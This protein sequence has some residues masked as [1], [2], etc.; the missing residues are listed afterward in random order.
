MNTSN[1]G[2]DFL[3]TTI[4][5]AAAA[6]VLSLAA[7]GGSGSLSKGPAGAGGNA[8]TITTGD[9]S[10][11]NGSSSGSGSGTGSGSGSGGGTTTGSN[12]G[13]TGSGGGSGGGSGSGG[14]TVSG[15]GSTV[16][17]VTTPVVGADT[18]NAAGSVVSN[19]GAAV[20]TLGDGVSAGLGTIGTSTDP[21]GTTLAS[22]GGVVQKTSDAVSSAG[23]LVSSLGTGVLSPLAP[24]TTP[25][26]SIVGIVGNA[27]TQ[28]GGVLDQTLTSA[29]VTQLTQT[30]SQAITPITAMV[31]TTT[32]T[33]GAATGLGQPVNNLLTALG[34]GLAQAGQNI[35]GSGG[36]LLVSGVGNL[37][38]ATGQTVASAGGLVNGT[39][40]SNPLA[41]ITGLLSGVAGS[42]TGTGTGAGGVLAP[43]AGLLGSA[44]GGTGAGGVLAPVAGLLGGAGGGTG[45]GNVLAPVTSLVG[46][47]GGA[48]SGATGS[49]GGTGTGTGGVLAPVTSLVG[50]LTG[51][52]TT[53]GSGGTGGSVSE[54]FTQLIGQDITIGKLIEVADSIT[55]MYKARGYALSF[56]FIPAQTFADGVVRVT[57]VEGYV[58]DVVIK[59]NPG[60]AE[61]RIRA[62]VQ[63]MR[64]DR[65]LRQA[66]FERVINVLGMIPG[67]E[68]QA[69]VAPPHNTDGAAT[70]TLD[71]ERKPVNVSTGIDFNHPGVQGL[72]SATENGMLG[73]GEALTASALLSKG[74]ND[75]TY[76]ALGGTL[77]I[78]TDG[79]IAKVDASHYHG[80]PVDN[81][82]LPSSIE[83]TVV[84]E[85]LALSAVY[86]FILSNT[87]SL[88]GTATVYA[89]HDEDRLKN[90]VVAGNP[91][92]AQRSQ[93]RVA[94]LQLDW[95]GI[96]VG[97]T[98]RASFNV[99]KAF[100]V[101]G[102]S[103][104]A[105]T[106]RAGY[107]PVNP[108]SLT[109]VRTGATYTQSNDWP[110][111]IGTVLSATGQYSSD[112]LPTSEQISFGA[113]RFAQGYQL[114]EASG[115]SGW[116][117]SFEVN[118]PVDIGMTYL[119]TVT[120]YV[121]IDAARVY[122][123]GG[124]ANPRR[125]SSV[126]I[127]FRVSDAKH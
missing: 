48:L 102:A 108:V 25:V 105:E 40:G 51:V 62:V 84:N 28:T 35:A 104:S 106:N 52:T 81:P 33:V 53:P 54:L 117:A 47:V 65:P 5:V 126:G 29:P 89:S 50:A 60:A 115:D 83:R 36:D 100:D 55:A 71:V 20:S 111:K 49:G 10:G 73:L 63:R 85:K 120:P 64:A 82:G 90:T 42:G 113:Q 59:G 93:I 107:A 125:L 8:D 121:A 69:T 78:G 3:R 38:S 127:G 77:P 116:G 103:K 118:R 95:T 46:G 24:V 97:V 74:R 80:H 67:V 119:K 39:P 122:L 22:A 18:A 13:G 87:R 76:Y 11:S 21:V 31:G 44:G 96:G 58:A 37:V 61:K 45:A 68:T 9:G 86:P 56:A 17:T 124:T 91:Q 109:F 70:L 72:V 41:P 75:Q 101:L 27:V 19:L 34:G 92:L 114:G 123:H 94:Q 2:C 12:G 15:T 43:V 112:T 23:T 57:I 32:Q 88:V 1:I 99:A 30:V 79:F 16:A 6:S 7:C 4:I 26:G 14:G 110:L 66:T 98:R